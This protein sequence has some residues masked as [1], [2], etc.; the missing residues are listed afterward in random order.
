[1]TLSYVCFVGHRFPLE[2]CICWVSVTHGDGSKSR[3]K[4]CNWWFA[5]AAST[6]GGT[7]TESC[8]SQNG[9]DPREVKVSWDHAPPLGAGKSLVS[10][11][12]LLASVQ[13][14]GDNLMGTIYDDLQ[15]QSRLKITSEL[16]KYAV[17]G[18]GGNASCFSPTPPMWRTRLPLVA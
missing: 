4:Q 2:D 9:A 5:A 12:Q 1:M 10:A 16:S 8:A 17:I 6:L 15:E 14:G 7:R 18:R 13:A 11:L 3:R